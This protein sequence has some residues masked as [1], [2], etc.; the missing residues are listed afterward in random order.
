MTDALRNTKRQVRLAICVLTILLGA[1]SARLHSQRGSVEQVNGRDAVAGEVIVKFRSTPNRGMYEQLQRDA[2]AEWLRPIGHAG[3]A[4]LHSRSLDA[5][6]LAARL[7]ARGDVVYVEPNYIVHAFV[8]PDDPLYPQLWGLA[9]IQAARAWDVS[10][11]T[12]SHVVA[13]IDTGVDY[14]HPDL[15]ANIWSAPSSFHVTIGG[16]TITCPAGSHGFNAITSTCDPMDD[17]KHGTHV[18]GTIGGVGNNGNGVAGVNWTTRLMAAKFL[19]ASGSGSLG[20]AVDAID[21]VI[22]TKQ[23]FGAAADVRVLSNSWGGG[24]FSQALLDEINAANDAEML[25]VA[26]AG[27]N[28]ANTDISPTYP[29][30][31]NAPNVVAV[32]ATDA[33]DAK[34]SFSNYGPTRVDLGAPGVGILSTVLGGGYDTFSGTSMATPHVSGAAALVLSQCSYDT[35]ALKDA[36]LDTVDPVPALASLTVTGGR[37]NVDSAVRTCVE[38][39][40][41]PT[42]LT[43]TGADGQV[44]LAWSTAFAALT[45]NV[46]RSTVQGGPYATVS[47][48]VKG[49]HFVDTTIVNGTTYY[50]VV[51]SS[52]VVGES[53][54]SNEASA[55]PKARPDLLISTLTVPSTAA[56]G[57]TITFTVVTKNQGLG[58]ANP[59]T[60]RFYLSRTPGIDANS[61]SLDPAQ[62]IGSLAAGATSSASPTVTLPAVAIGTYFVIAKADADNVETETQEFNNTTARSIALGPDLIVTTSGPSSAAPG[63]TMTIA[64]TVKNQGGAAADATTL[65]YYLSSDALFDSGD[66]PLSPTRAV[67]ALPAGAANAGSTT[68]TIPPTTAAGTYFLF[69]KADADNVVTETQEGNNT[70]AKIIQIGGDLVVSAFTVPS[71]GGN[72]TTITV[73]DTTKN[74][75]AAAVAASTTRFFFSPNLTFDSSDTPLDGSRPVPAL[76]AGLTSTGQTTLTLPTGLAVGSY[77]VIAVADGDNAVPE[78]VE[79]NNATARAIA[80]GPDLTLTAVTVPFMVTAGSTISVNATVT[81]QGGD[82]AGASTLRFYLSNDLFF[83]AG[84]APLADRAVLPLAGGASSVGSTSITIPAGKTPGTYYII[85]VVDADGAVTESVETNNTRVSVISV[86]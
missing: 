58:A 32:L 8:E 42:G 63:G 31:Y 20:D 37:L 73:T 49:P 11:G 76:A 26:A 59:T 12:T 70:A 83:D 16:T 5:A 51:S 39:P 61:W 29:G 68:L 35:A 36:L 57:A 52:N 44:T 67:P 85:A 28:G 78:S 50:Y 40:S 60:T 14:T 80:I 25:F 71:N 41:A 23:H 2:D 38:A 45:Y 47:S 81:N 77:F 53:A 48:G 27:N 33:N 10:T 3:A 82:P 86:K 64:D 6:T 18:A 46:K 13:I 66:T 74:N 69:A 54:N 9:K 72:G 34:A 56:P 1:L 43:A 24:P 75:G 7:A 30:S 4:R 84:D 21:F 55:T 19:D 79:T 65:R 15:A 22:Q 62:A 17:H